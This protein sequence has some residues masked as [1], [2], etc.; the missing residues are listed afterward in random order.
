[1]TG[2]SAQAG[3]FYFVSFRG[4]KSIGREKHPFS[5]TSAPKNNP[6]EIAFTIQKLGDFTKKIPSVQIG[7]RV[8]L[9]GPYGQFD[10]IIRKLPK[11]QPLVFYGLGSGLAPLLSLAEQYGNQRQIKILWSSS[12]K[13]GLYFEKALEKLKKNP[14]IT[15]I[16]KE[17]R[18]TEESIKKNCHQKKL[19]KGSTLSWDQL[20]SS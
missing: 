6:H 14:N 7:T 3:D 11:D 5:V 1:M 16:A 10:R 4:S 18:F 19:I 9:E 8:Y 12:K 13:N 15:V 17:G 2:H 20:M